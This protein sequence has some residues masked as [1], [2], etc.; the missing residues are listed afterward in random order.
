MSTN[1]SSHKIP[2]GYRSRAD[3][4]LVPESMVSDIDKL[5]DQTI[6]TLI[7]QAEEKS[8]DLA[9]FK[10]QAFSDIE[11]FVATSLEQYQVK[12]GGKK[13]NLTLVTFDGNYKIVR[14]IAG[15]LVFDERLQAAKELL[16]EFFRERMEGLEI[17][18]DDIRLL[19]NHVFRVDQEGKINVGEVL[20]LRRIPIT[21][22]KWQLAMQAISD[23][24][25]VAGTKPYVR[26]YRRKGDSDQYEPII[27][28]L[29]AV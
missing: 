8:A 1:P 21:H 16:D 4:T 7:G 11:A 18:Y 10:A 9:R 28:D 12:A 6:M 5:R 25:M 3:G 14:H 27:L 24:V 26:F 22:A 2:A 15:R 20:G 29:A 17:D 19:V 23:S 13:G